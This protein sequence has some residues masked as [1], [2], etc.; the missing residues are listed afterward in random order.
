MPSSRVTSR[1][2]LLQSTLSA[3]GVGL[4]LG[5]ILRLRANAET[6]QA[7]PADTAVIQIWLGGGPSQFET[8]DPKPDAPVEFRGPYGAIQTKFSGVLFCETMPRTATVLDRAAIVRTVT[9][10]TNDH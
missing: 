10:P 4:S 5:D 6:E 1:R 9:H 7:R 3:G 8:F 2:Q